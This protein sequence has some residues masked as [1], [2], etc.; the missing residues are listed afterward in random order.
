MQWEKFWYRDFVDDT[1]TISPASRGLWISIL[2]EMWGNGRVGQIEFTE[3]K[4]E[5]IGGFTSKDENVKEKLVELWHNGIC[6]MIDPDNNMIVNDFNLIEKRG[7]FIIRC[8][9]LWKEEKERE[10][11]NL[12]QK[13]YESKNKP[14]NKMINSVLPN[15]AIEERRRE[16]K[17]KEERK[18]LKEVLLK[19][20]KT[21]SEAYPGINLQNETA[22]AQAWIESNPQNKKSNLKR[23]LNNWLSK[24]QD[25]INKYPPKEVKNILQP[26]KKFYCPNCKQENL[27]SSIFEQGCSICLK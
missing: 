12:A 8:R 20:E 27:K 18:D 11:H 1:K 25:S 3:D 9:R 22:K 16:D 10:S 19:H 26:I 15:D 17:K 5:R 2:C 14:Y 13:K 24:A 23:F 4:L 7:V 21:F 6:D